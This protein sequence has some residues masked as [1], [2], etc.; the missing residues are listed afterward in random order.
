MAV[1]GDDPLKIQHRAGH[2]DFK[3][4]QGYIREVEHLRE[5]FGTPFPTL[6]AD[7]VSSG[8]SSERVGRNGHAYRIKRKF[9][10]GEAGLE[11]APF[12]KGGQSCVT[13]DIPRVSSSR[14]LD[15]TE[16]EVT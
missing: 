3:T 9:S 16:L 14:R 5:G 13:V 7:L 11:T 2:K 8:I 12:T 1:R 4:T 10:V 15:G 6:P